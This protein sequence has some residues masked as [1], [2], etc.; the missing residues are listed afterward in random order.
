MGAV[1]IAIAWR[2]IFLWRLT[3]SARAS[4]QT[5]RERAGADEFTIA[6]RRGEVDAGF[7]VAAPSGGD[8]R[9]RGV[10]KGWG[11]GPD[12]CVKDADDDGA[13]SSISGTERG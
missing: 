3:R 1:A 11:F 8:G 10:I 7:A 2:V 6:E 9:K 13:R 4:E 12:A 5:A